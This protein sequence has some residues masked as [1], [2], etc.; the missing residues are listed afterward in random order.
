MSATFARQSLAGLVAR[1]RETIPADVVSSA[2][3]IVEDVRRR[4]EAALREHAT[5]LDGLEP[6]SPLVVGRADMAQA[7]DGLLPD[8]RSRLTRIADRIRAFAEGQRRSIGPFETS[9]PGGRA[10]HEVA[11]VARAGCYAPGGRYPLPSSLLMTAITARAAGVGE[12]W[13]AS[14]R[15]D[16]I[17]LACAALAGADGFLVAGGAQAIAALAFGAG[18]VPAC[19][20]VVGPGNAYVTAAKQLV[21]GQVGIDS[22]AGP[23]ELVV[24]ADETGDPR[25]IAA[26]LLAQAEHDPRS[27]PLLVCTG[28]LLVDRV[29][30]ELC[31]QLETLPTADVARTALGNGGAV[32]VRNLDEAVAACDELAPEHLHLHIANAD[33]IVPRLRHYGALFIG[34]A[35]AE[36]LGD[37]G[38]GPNHVLPTGR[39]SRYAGGLS[40]LTFLRV[41]TWLAMQDVNAG[42]ALLDDAVWLGRVEGLEA[43]ARSAAIRLVGPDAK[44][45]PGGVP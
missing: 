19:D 3:G 4:G 28:D 14:P 7:L 34:S 9:I 8:E 15:R 25:L 36:V 41:R 38:A 33:A 10:G 16:R 26:D 22:L 43:H 44:R 39:A 1:S 30:G 2:R 6:E 12:V 27:V 37:Y 21:F 23:S 32:V 29:A 18:E 31:A 35:S 13:V 24:V 42:R 5:R 20:V 17:M 45:G 11:P 40:V